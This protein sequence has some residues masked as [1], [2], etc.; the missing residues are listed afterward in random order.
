MATAAPPKKYY[1][2]PVY[3]CRPMTRQFHLDRQGFM[4]LNRDCEIGDFLDEQLVRAHYYPQTEAL[5]EEVTG[6]LV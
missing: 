1:D 6:A 4:L 2:V 3:D 5:L